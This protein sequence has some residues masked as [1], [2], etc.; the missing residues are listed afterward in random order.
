M[1]G[2]MRC[3]LH[4]LVLLAVAWVA[5][6]AVA[7]SQE[8]P[9]SQAAG[10]AE[11][12]TAQ[13]FDTSKVAN[14]LAETEASL[15]PPPPETLILLSGHLQSRGLEQAAASL[16]AKVPA[17]TLVE[18]LLR[19]DETEAALAVIHQWK[20]AEPDAPR[21]AL[22]EAVILF[23]RGDLTP[24]F[25][26]LVGLDRRL[27]TADDAAL[28]R[29]LRDLLELQ[30]KTGRPAGADNN[31]WNARFVGDEGVF[32]AGYVVASER[33]KISSDALPAM[34]QLLR[35]QP[36]LGW[37]WALSGEMVNAEGDVQTARKCFER[38]KNLKYVPSGQPGRIQARLDV[39]DAY[40]AE[41]QNRLSGAAAPA[42]RGAAPGGWSNLVDRPQALVVVA[43]GLMVIAW[44]AVLQVRQWRRSRST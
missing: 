14:L 33:S 2:E 22:L 41:Q 1:T 44:I 18:G 16:R 5:V 7:T 21:A 20:Q 42:E 23:S 24:A 39:L 11:A 13:P 17:T 19:V 29:L 3:S 30:S 43:L 40:L 34:L 8:S 38:A 31:P 32:S 10:P 36:R 35:L 37:A 25:E 27:P 4:T 6:G 15:L 28:A 9:Q 26:L 12:A